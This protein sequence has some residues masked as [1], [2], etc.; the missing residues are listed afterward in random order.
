M[1]PIGLDGP[2]TYRD[3]LAALHKADL[4]LTLPP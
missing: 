1:G 2:R 3:Y 4:P